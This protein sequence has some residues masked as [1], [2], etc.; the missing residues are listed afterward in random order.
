ME[1]RKQIWKI[2]LF[3]G[4]VPFL[5]AIGFCFITSLTGIWSFWDYLILYSFLYWP[6]YVLGIVLIA[7]SVAKIKK[8]H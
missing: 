6:T 2:L 5:I 3:L 1:Q 4:C 7:L 8:K